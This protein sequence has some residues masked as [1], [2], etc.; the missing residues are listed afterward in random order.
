MEEIRKTNSNKMHST[1]KRKAKAKQ[2]AAPLYHASVI[3]SADEPSAN[4]SSFLGREDNSVLTRIKKCLE[5]AKGA[6]ASEA[7]A[8]VA[9]RLASRLMK[10]LNVTQAEVLAHIEPEERKKHA[11][12]STVALKRLDGNCFKR[13]QEAYYLCVLAYAMRV[14][15][16]CKSYTTSGHTAFKTTFYGI[17]ENTVAAA[18]AYCMVYN[19]MLEW[20][21]PYKGI[22]GKSSY[23]HGVCNELLTTAER[24][25]KD[26]ENAARKAEQDEMYARIEQER[27]ERQAQLDRLAELPEEIEHSADAPHATE[28]DHSARIDSGMEDSDSPRAEKEPKDGDDGVSYG[29]GWDWEEWNGLSDDE[30][31]IADVEAGPSRLADFRDDE[32]Q[33]DAALQDLDDDDFDAHFDNLVASVEQPRDTSLIGILPARPNGKAAVTSADN[34]TVDLTGDLAQN[35]TV[36][37]TVGSPTNETAEDRTGEESTQWKSHM[38]LV[39]FRDAAK[40]IADK[41]LAEQAI[42]LVRPRKRK[43]VQH[44]WDAYDDGVRDSKKIDVRVKS[45]PGGPSAG[46]GPRV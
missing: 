12:Q 45:L 29:N 30:D 1:C 17:A 11:G 31:D 21:R 7:E 34:Q 23:C 39:R 28:I 33:D 14:F 25:K 37:L 8:K 16:D 32:E 5:R 18:N 9:L 10:T 41:Y 35:E 27:A 19:L 6:A 15:F 44:D 3:Q 42:K 40:D 2:H 24:E 4:T 36:D 13:V 46:A 20:A 22:C 43:A 38:Q 26:E